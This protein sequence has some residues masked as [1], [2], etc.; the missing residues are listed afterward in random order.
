MTGKNVNLDTIREFNENEIEQEFRYQRANAA[1]RVIGVLFGCMF[2]AMSVSALMVTV[3]ASIKISTEGLL[4]SGGFQMSS[5]WAMLAAFVLSVIAG[6]L[7]SLLFAICSYACFFRKLSRKIG[8]S[9]A[10]IIVLGVVTFGGAAGIAM[11]SPSDHM[12]DQF[13]KI[14]ITIPNDFSKITSLESDVSS[15]SV[16]YIVSSSSKIT[17]QT[18]ND[19]KRPQIAINGQ[20]ATIKFSDSDAANNWLNT[21]SVLTIYGPKLDFLQVDNG[22]FGYSAN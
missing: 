6:L 17:F 8:I 5:G 4:L 19:E 21:Q 7:L 9:I 16:R 15:A 22:V 13:E 1:R 20:K 18:L 12:I 10:S 14:N 2:L 11:M 3:L